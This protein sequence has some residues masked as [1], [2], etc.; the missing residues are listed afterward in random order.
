MHEY[1]RTIFRKDKIRSAINLL[2]MQSK[3]ES[4]AMYSASNQLFGLRVTSANT[5]H[6]SATRCNVHDINQNLRPCANCR[7]DRARPHHSTKASYAGQA[8]VRLVRPHHFQTVCMPE[9]RYWNT[10]RRPIWFVISIRRAHSRGVRRRGAC[11]SALLR[12]LTRPLI[13]RGKRPSRILRPYQAE[14]KAVTFWRCFSA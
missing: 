13:A 12:F 4:A 5:R 1:R 11:A 9:C 8:H 2:R 14:A 7:R 3:A 6:H 10:E